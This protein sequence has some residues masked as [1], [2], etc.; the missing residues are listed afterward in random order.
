MRKLT[1]MQD[2]FVAAYLLNP[3]AALAAR[4]AGYNRLDSA[5]HGW[6]NLQNPRIQAAIKAAKENHINGKVEGA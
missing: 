1:D 3:N 2:L 5:H 4:I 6:R